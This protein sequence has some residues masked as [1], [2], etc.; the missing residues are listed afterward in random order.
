MPFFEEISN[1][2]NGKTAQNK[3]SKKSKK[4]NKHLTS[5][6]VGL[7]FW[8]PGSEDSFSGDFFGE[9]WVCPSSDIATVSSGWNL[10]LRIVLNRLDELHRL[11][12]N[13]VDWL[14]LLKISHG[15]FQQ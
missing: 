9:S 6:L 8:I 3:N 15:V 10:L 5:D 13:I 1:K 7:L 11:K 2:R 14:T 12:Y 4:I